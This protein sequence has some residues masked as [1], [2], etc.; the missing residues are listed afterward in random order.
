MQVALWIKELFAP[1]DSPYYYVSIFHVNFISL[2]VFLFSYKATK[3]MN[4]INMN[5]FISLEK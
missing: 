4:L 2:T 5:L 3:C 1:D